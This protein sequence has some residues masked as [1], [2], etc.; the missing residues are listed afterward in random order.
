MNIA[1]I[2]T[3]YIAGRHTS[4]LSTLKNITIVGH[5]DVNLEAAQKAAKQWGG[6][7]YSSVTELLKQEQ[8]DA[9]WICIPP[10]AH[11][12]VEAICLAHNIPMYIEKPIGLDVQE[13][14]AINETIIKNN[15]IVNVGYYWRC[16][17]IIPKLKEMLTET[18]PRLVR[19]AYHGPTAPA[20]W[21]HKESMSGGQIVEQATHLIDI[22]RFLLGEAKVVESL[23]AHHDRSAFTDLDIATV[24]AAL[25]RFDSGLFGTVTTT[26][27]LDSFIDTSIEFL[28]DNRKITLSLKELHIDNSNGRTTILTCTDPLLLA[29]QAFITAVQSNNPNALPCSYNE[30]LKTQQLCCAIRDAAKEN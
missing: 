16:L 9:V 5:V 27:I 13:P 7:A 11:G 23:S 2:G 29:D 25:V 1:F 20:L 26:C 22:A 19:I 28:C 21:W 15:A 12:E 24:T 4:A 14:I 3:G 17:E 10:F 6:H 30:A 8:V 18:P